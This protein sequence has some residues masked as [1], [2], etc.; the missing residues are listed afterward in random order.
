MIDCVAEIAELIVR[1]TVTL[2]CPAIQYFAEITESE[3]FTVLYPLRK[4]VE[5]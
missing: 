3:R 2:N 4:Y 1:I 5:H